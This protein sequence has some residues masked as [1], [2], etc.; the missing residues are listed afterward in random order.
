M[1][2]CLAIAIALAAS[3]ALAQ[4]ARTCSVD[5][6][7][8]PDDVRPIVERWLAGARRCAIPLEVRIVASDDGL[9]VIARDDRGNVRDRVVPDAQTAGALIASWADD[10]QPAAVASVDI[11]A[12]LMAPAPAGLAVPPVANAAG[13][14]PGEAPAAV[15]DGGRRASAGPHHWLGEYGMIG[16]GKPT[17]RGLRGEVDLLRGATWTAGMTFTIGNDDLYASNDTMQEYVQLI[18]YASTIYVAHPI[19]RGAWELRPTIGAGVVYSRVIDEVVGSP[20]FSL[21]RESVQVS[22]FAEASLLGSRDL[23]GHLAIAAGVVVSAYSQYFAATLPDV[24][25]RGIEGAFFTGL[26]FGFL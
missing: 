17:F 20:T 23:V 13:L 7:R 1:R 5:L 6:V 9:Y 2:T 22:P 21:P 10:G 19:R 25:H 11:H 18:D 15:D 8:A 26:R 3:P 16:T 4:P 12:E 14:P 24:Q